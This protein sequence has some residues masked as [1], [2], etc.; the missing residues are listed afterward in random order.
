MFL[1]KVKIECKAGNGGNGV[2]AFRREKY[3]PNGGP[4]G[5]DGGKGGDIIF[6]VSKDLDNLGDFRFKKKFKADNGEDGSGNN[7]FGKNGRD[8]YIYVPKGTV[9]RNATTNKVVADLVDENDEQIILKGGQGGRGNSHFAT[10]TRQAPRF[11]EQGVVT[12]PFELILELKTLADVG[13]VGFP[14]VGKSTLLS[15][16]S[17]AKPKIANY[18]FTT[19]T[20][21]IAV[22]NA[23]G[24]SFVMA[25]IPGLISG[26]SEG[27]GLGIEFLRH[28]ER[29]RLLVHVVDIAGTEGRDPLDD[30]Y[31]INNEL[32]KYGEKVGN[33]PQIIALNKSD[34]LIDDAPIQE[35]K[36]VVGDEVSVFVISAHTHEGLDKLIE[37][38]IKTLQKLPK[39]QKLE[40]EEFDIDKRNLREF[41]VAKISE[42]VF[43][44]KGELV[45]EI[46][47]RVNLDDM[48][49]NA[50]FQKRIKNDGII[51]ALLE[52]G[53]QEGDMIH[54]GDYELQYF[55]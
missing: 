52:I 19:I 14:N 54:I 53:M 17:N 11:A 37:C 38:V 21:N 22:V 35:F 29:T 49:S 8:L 46:M 20:P 30:Y 25:D 45:F 2:V 28:I 12:K 41:E 4:N 43:E 7:K 50:Y 6:K 1:D 39:E 24:N 16:V 23:F 5:G 32:A 48:V 10:S 18:H 26:A 55:E 36:D 40:I 27:H 9:V 33:L 51:D 13:L 47:K 42:G 34:M 15:S 44:V 31:A 3:V